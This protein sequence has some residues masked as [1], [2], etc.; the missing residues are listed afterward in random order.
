MDLE[1]LNPHARAGGIKLPGTVAT[2]NAGQE[3]EF[4]VRGRG[5]GGGGGRQHHGLVGQGVDGGVAHSGFEVVG[6]VEGREGG[7]GGGEPGGG[8]GLR[9][10]GRGG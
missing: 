6:R 2:A 3:L 10:G 9:R 4:D 8:W 1:I 7:E 5:P